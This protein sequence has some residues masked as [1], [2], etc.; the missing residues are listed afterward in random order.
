MN[1]FDEKNIRSH[2]FTCHARI[3][4]SET[5]PPNL[6]LVFSVSDGPECYFPFKPDTELDEWG[7]NS[8][9]TAI[10]EVANNM[11]EAAQKQEAYH[12]IEDHQTAYLVQGQTGRLVDGPERLVRWMV[13]AFASEERAH[14]LM[15]TLNHWC[16]TN[17]L[18][19]VA[20]EDP[21]RRLIID[22]EGKVAKCPHDPGFRI[23]ETG[24]LYTIVRVPL[25]MFDPIHEG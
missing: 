16:M 23:D 17:G 20:Y 22:P 21:M 1:P 11:I 7:E 10:T 25:D 12:L 19:R 2:G 6:N 8:L 13:K 5:D 24:V 9:T 14:D 15:R 4:P 18:S 3:E